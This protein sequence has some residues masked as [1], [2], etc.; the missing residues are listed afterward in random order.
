MKSIIIDILTGVITKLLDSLGVTK[1]WKKLKKEKRTN[2]I[3]NE[4]HE[5]DDKAIID[6][7]NRELYN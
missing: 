3:E 4:L 7:L 5:S 6:R 1:A 2:V